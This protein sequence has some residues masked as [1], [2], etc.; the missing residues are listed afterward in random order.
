MF[1]TQTCEQ[2][3]EDFTAPDYMKD[4]D[5]SS[6][7][8]KEMVYLL[9]CTLE[10]RG[11]ISFDVGSEAQLSLV[12]DSQDF[13]RGSK[14]GMSTDIKN[15]GLEPIDVHDY[16]S[17]KVDG[18]YA[19]SVHNMNSDSGVELPRGAATLVYERKSYTNRGSGKTYEA[20]STRSPLTVTD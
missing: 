13:R 3:I 16:G 10:F 9:H 20:Y 1:N 17:N 18:W 8:S 12:D 2:V 6:G 4:T 7:A 19:I 11:D 5:S 15:A 14:V